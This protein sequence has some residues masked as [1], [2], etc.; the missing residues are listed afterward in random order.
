MGR[1][2]GRACF[3]EVGD[4][5]STQAYAVGQGLG[6]EGSALCWWT[7]NRSLSTLSSSQWSLFISN[8]QIMFLYLLSQCDNFLY[9]WF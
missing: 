5:D 6:S 1:T 2:E 8:L 7:W 9:S 4:A 3:F